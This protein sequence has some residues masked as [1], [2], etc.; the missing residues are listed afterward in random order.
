MIML[1]TVNCFV[2]RNMSVLKK[3]LEEDGVKFS[4]LKKGWTTTITINKADIPRIFPG[5]SAYKNTTICKNY[6]FQK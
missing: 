5:I 3:Q 2:K 4:G 1:I 6:I